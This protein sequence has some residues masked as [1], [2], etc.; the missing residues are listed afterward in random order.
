MREPVR[1]FLCMHPIHGP[2]NAGPASGTQN[3]IWS[4]STQRLLR[5]NASLSAKRQLCKYRSIP[6]TVRLSK[7]KF[8]Q[9]CGIR[10]Q[11]RDRG[12]H[13]LAGDP[14]VAGFGK[15]WGE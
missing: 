7:V 12:F 3:H 4:L 11:A 10:A 1:C 9:R 5:Q 6:E 15:V 8:V 13:S 14:T 2:P